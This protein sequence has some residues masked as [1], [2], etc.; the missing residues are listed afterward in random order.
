MFKV[1]VRVLL[2]TKGVVQSSVI[3]A[4]WK[5]NHL[6][7][8]FKLLIIFGISDTASPH[9]ETILGPTMVTLLIN[10]GFVWVP[11]HE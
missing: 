9:P 7:Q 1:F 2:H 11:H 3:S 6:T 8:S 5:Q 10:A 4:G